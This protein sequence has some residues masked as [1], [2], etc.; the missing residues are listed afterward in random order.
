MSTDAIHQDQPVHT[1]G[2][3]L[4]DAQAGL[5]LLHG[6]GASAQGMLQLADDL[7]V[8]DIA[9]LAPQA[10]MRSWYPQ[11]FMAPRDQNEPELASALSTIGDV[12][13][14]L[15][16]AGIGPA[17]TVLLG[18][19]QGACLAT[20]YAAQTPQ[21][22]G[23]VVGLSGGLIGPEGASFDYEGS[24]DATPVFLGC[25]DQDPYIPRAR[26]AETADVLRALNAD[27]TPRIYEGLGHTIN[28]DERQHARSLLRRC[29]DSDTA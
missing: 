15:A 7:D 13:S 3:P 18:F 19:S 29:V 21:R 2:A 24:L 27:V 1:G 26:V 20:T 11:S 8:P 10:R 4:D 23:G 16:D 12:L 25:S 22:Y 17:R 9:H 5:V 6:R 14:R 28:D